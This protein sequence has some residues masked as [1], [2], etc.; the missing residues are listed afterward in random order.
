V[1]KGEEKTKRPKGRLRRLRRFLLWSA[2]LFSAFLI[3]LLLVLRILFPPERIRTMLEQNLSRQLARPV[4]I[5]KID[6]NPFGRLDVKGVKIAFLPEE[7]GE[8]ALFT[9]SRLGVRFR[10]LPLLN[11]RFVI[12]EVW[13]EEPRIHMLDRVLEMVPPAE[14]DT[15]PKEVRSLPV[16]LGVSSLVLKDFHFRFSAGRGEERQSLAIEGLWLEVSDFRVPRKLFSSYQGLQG[17][18]RIYT[19]EGKVF[20][21]KGEVESDYPLN[22]EWLIRISPSGDWIVRGDTRLDMG[23]KLRERGIG[24]DFDLAGSGY[25]EAV[26]L[27]EGRFHI[28]GEEI[29][30][31]SGTIDRMNKGMH[32][33]MRLDGET[34]SLEKILNA[35][36]R[37]QFPGLP[38]LAGMG[39][40]RGSA[41]VEGSVQGS[42]E[43]LRFENRIRVERFSLQ[44]T[45][46]GLGVKETDMSMRVKG[47]WD[48]GIARN[49]GVRGSVLSQDIEFQQNDTL[50]LHTG[51]VRAEWSTGM[52]STL[53]PTQGNAV[54]TL[55]S[56]MGGTGK[57]D[58]SWEA[59]GEG[60]D[61]QEK[62]SLK[63][64]VRFDSLRM[65][66][67]PGPGPFPEGT[68]SI[69][70]GLES[71]GLQKFR[72]RFSAM[73]PPLILHTGSEPDTL[74]FVD[75]KSWAWVETDTLFNLW[76]MDSLKVQMGD[77]L[78]ARMRGEFL[79]EGFILDLNLE[80]SVNNQAFP[81]YLPSGLRNRL[82][83]LS[84]QGEEHFHM[85]VRARQGSDTLEVR[86]SGWL[87]VDRVSVRG[88]LAG[89]AMEDLSGKCS[90]QGTPAALEGEVEFGTGSVS[91][92]RVFPEPLRGGRLKGHFAYSEQNGVNLDI[93]E[94]VLE[95]LGL[96]AKLNAELTLRDPFPGINAGA[97][98]HWFRSDTL[99][100]IEGAELTGGAVVRIQAT[101]G[102][103]QDSLLSVSG[104]FRMDSLTV[105]QGKRLAVH[106][107]NGF[108]P[109]H[110][111]IDLSGKTIVPER[112]RRERN[113]LKYE[114]ERDLYRSHFPSIGFLRIDRIQVE[115][116]Q[117]EDIWLDVEA[118]SGFL[119]V[120]LF[121]VRLLDGN[122]GGALRVRWDGADPDGIEYEMKAQVSRIDAASLSGAVGSR[123]DRT[124]LDATMAFRGKG[125]DI[126]QGID[127][128]GYFHITNI[129]SDFAGTLLEGLDPEGSNRS[130]RMTRRLLGMG[131]KPKLFS[132]DLRH[133]YVYPSLELNQ[134]WF[135]PLRIPGRL[136]YGRLPLAFFIQ[137]RSREP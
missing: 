11:R 38:D 105:F 85:N 6:V 119:D 64:D 61:L 69:R 30:G 124:E 84:V 86:M 28:G 136:E 65:D 131:W 89:V 41:A 127:L 114:R 56:F 78:N 10:L 18:I 83:D 102:D 137:S 126:E 39:E 15:T 74:P 42:L 48:G 4:F 36:G 88:S 95:D 82:P 34:F 73:I 121:G 107:I 76:K 40:I 112:G 26:R 118:G 57:A 71:T 59:S 33:N 120:P 60:P 90:F 49:V 135:S 44:D 96:T 53:F 94:A 66:T 111:L 115:S 98:I 79:R 9:L 106:R 14:K 63:A 68:V 7:S 100:L 37:F 87:Q 22:V 113:W 47:G 81:G 24:W 117:V 19:R 32:L 46:N 101:T 129:E 17:E 125:I 122:V 3:L 132:F 35:L 20:W 134:P 77:L 97:E 55:S 110:V 99:A 54:L 51:P 58:L 75:I 8:G 116:Y 23:E 103:S 21:Q 123:G 25:D 45:L 91:L 62:V 72:T 93:G 70:A 29:L 13:L 31:A 80:G 130:I 128:D 27:N 50:I 108:V 2:A 12:R 5:E 52:D 16:G 43:Q 133:G 104:D 109:F 67:F 92:D 1:I